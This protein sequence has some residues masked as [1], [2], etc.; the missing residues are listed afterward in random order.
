VCKQ[1]EADRTHAVGMLFVTGR[2]IRAHLE[3]MVPRCVDVEQAAVLAGQR[4]KALGVLLFAG[5]LNRCVGSPAVLSAFR[6]NSRRTLAP[7]SRNA[8][9]TAAKARW[10]AG[11]SPRSKAASSSLRCRF[12]QPPIP[13]GRMPRDL[14]AAADSCRL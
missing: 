14:V 4:D 11:V 10:T 9:S 3:A 5:V 12:S 13:V 7:R 6:W 2:K 1:A 8:A